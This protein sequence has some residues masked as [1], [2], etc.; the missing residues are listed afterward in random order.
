M[1]HIV[2]ENSRYYLIKELLSLNLVSC[3]VDSAN[4]L[5]FIAASIS[6]CDLQSLINCYFLLILIWRNWF[7][8][9]VILRCLLLSEIKYF[10]G[11]DFQG[12]K[13]L[14]INS[15]CKSMKVA[16]YE[17]QGLKIKIKMRDTKVDQSVLSK[18]IWMHNSFI[19]SLCKVPAIKS[20]CSNWPTT[21]PIFIWTMI[22]IEFCFQ[23]QA[24]QPIF[25]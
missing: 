6:S 3:C 11:T 21:V 23:G 25:S 16:D 4:F 5:K 8:D 15:L 12:T 2:D 18:V 9:F 10:T 19:H 1:I 22:I 17:I 24:R 13:L 20:Q 7:I 14:F